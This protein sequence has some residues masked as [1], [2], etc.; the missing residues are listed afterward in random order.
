MVKSTATPRVAAIAISWRFH[1]GRVSFFSNTSL[2][3]MLSEAAPRDAPHTARAALPIAKPAVAVS[4]IRVICV[5]SIAAMSPGSCDASISTPSCSASLGT[6]S[7]VIVM[8]STSIGN[9]ANSA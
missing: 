5:C 2:S 8:T 9:S 4:S 1:Q 3:A 7:R 6:T